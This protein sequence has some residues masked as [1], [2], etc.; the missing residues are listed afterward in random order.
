MGLCLRSNVLFFSKRWG[1]IGLIDIAVEGTWIWTDGSPGH[2]L[3]PF[4]CTGTVPVWD[5]SWVYMTPSHN[6]YLQLISVTFT[7]H[8][9]MT[10]EILKTVQL[11]LLM[12]SGLI[13]RALRTDFSTSVRQVRQCPVC[14]GPLSTRSG[15][16]LTLNTKTPF[17]AHKLFC[18]FHPPMVTGVG[19]SNT[20]VNTS[21]ARPVASRKCLAG[22]SA[23]Q[24]K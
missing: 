17:L 19:L 5:L 23:S 3:F 22:N 21:T 8:S 14:E 2:F 1:W 11:C 7:P 4:T 12:E 18:G 15:R 10:L 9:L 24:C 13:W 16:Y 20:T 6:V